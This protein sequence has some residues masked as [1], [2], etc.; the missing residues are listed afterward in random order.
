MGQIIYDKHMTMTIYDEH[1]TIYDTE[2]FAYEFW[3][4]EPPANDQ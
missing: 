4:A 2:Q 1:M 3:Q